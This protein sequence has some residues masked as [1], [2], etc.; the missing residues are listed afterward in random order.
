VNLVDNSGATPLTVAFH[1]SGNDEIIRILV[2]AGADLNIGHHQGYSPLN[3]AVAQKN[4]DVVELML[5]RG[6]QKG[7]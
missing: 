4:K 1:R 7:L 3:L 6:A 2:A 5:A